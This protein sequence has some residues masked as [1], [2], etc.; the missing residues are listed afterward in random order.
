MVETLNST[1]AEDSGAAPLHAAKLSIS[2]LNGQRSSCLVLRVVSASS[3]C[4]VCGPS[5]DYTRYHI[6]S[7]HRPLQDV[8]NTLQ[9]FHPPAFRPL[10]AYLRSMQVNGNASAS[11]C[12]RSPLGIAGTRHRRSSRTMLSRRRRV[13]VLPLAYCTGPESEGRK[14][15]R[16]LGT[17][18]AL[19]ARDRSRTYTAHRHAHAIAY[20]SSMPKVNENSAALKQAAPKYELVTQTLSIMPKFENFRLYIF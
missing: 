10:A 7:Y 6:I 16:H 2:S 20:L 11:A 17:E 1:L 12:A 15:F 13:R 18:A 5:C 4:H 3:H 19:Q 14:S 9:T 8:E